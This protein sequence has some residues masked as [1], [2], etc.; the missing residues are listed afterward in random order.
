MTGL[1][2][3]RP[4]PRPADVE[5][6][7]R[8]QSRTAAIDR[9]MTALGDRLRDPEVQDGARRAAAGLSTA[10]GAT[11]DELGRRGRRDGSGV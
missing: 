9:A 1:R 7:R 6:E 5:A 11:V 3:T 10:V 4:E 2:Q 8:E